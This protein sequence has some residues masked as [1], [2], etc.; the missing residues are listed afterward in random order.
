MC[1]SRSFVPGQDVLF[2]HARSFDSQLS[3]LARRNWTV[4]RDGR[5][6]RIFWLWLT[7]SHADRSLPHQV[8]QD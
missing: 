5:R 4:C 1:Q 2:E 3:R 8:R 7:D 6:Q